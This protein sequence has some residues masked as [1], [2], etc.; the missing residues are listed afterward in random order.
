MAIAT[1][2]YIAEAAEQALTGLRDN[3]AVDACPD[4]ELVAEVARLDV[5]EV[6]RRMAE[7][8]RPYVALLDGSPAGYGWVASER[9]SIGELGLDIE[10]PARHLYLW[11]FGTLPAFRGRG[12]YPRLL[13]EIVRRESVQGDRFWIIYAPEN[14][15]SAAGIERAGFQP[16]A[17]LSFGPDGRTALGVAGDE[18]LADMARALLNLPVIAEELDPC[19]RCGGCECERDERGHC[20]CAVARSRRSTPVDEKPAVV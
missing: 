18:A 2:T 10:L 11:D 3:L 8:H 6:E 14:L 5:I 7:H 20:A 4:S 1:R 15:P 19:W 9:A 17:E 13:A 12:V 16:A